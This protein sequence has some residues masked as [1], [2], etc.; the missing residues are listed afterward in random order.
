[1]CQRHIALG[2]HWKSSVAIKEARPS[3]FTDS[4]LINYILSGFSGWHNFEL[5]N[6]CIEWVFQDWKWMVGRWSRPQ[7]IVV[8]LQ[9]KI[10]FHVASLFR[11]EFFA[12]LSYPVSAFSRVPLFIVNVSRYKIK[13][14]KATMSETWWSW[15]PKRL[16]YI[17]QWATP[18]DCR[19]PTV[20]QERNWYFI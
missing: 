20:P 17:E 1:M 11:A 10:N 6:K 9:V 13:D 5:W 7:W 4:Y 15:P 19:C 8:V 2:N 3:A 12:R 14:K 18:T 16:S